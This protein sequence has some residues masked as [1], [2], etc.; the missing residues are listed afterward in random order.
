M[1]VRGIEISLVLTSC[2]VWAAITAKNKGFIIN[3]NSVIL[4][5]RKVY[6]VSRDLLK[7]QMDK[8][9]LVK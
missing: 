4:F 1:Y 7:I 6:L 3:R 5:W 9:P 8:S 2:K